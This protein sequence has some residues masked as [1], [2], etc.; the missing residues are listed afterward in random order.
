M[1]ARGEGAWRCRAFSTVFLDF[2]KREVTKRCH[3]ARQASL[4]R[5]VIAYARFAPAATSTNVVD[6]LVSLAH[7]SFFPP[8]FPLF[9]HCIDALQTAFGVRLVSP[10]VQSSSAK[11]A[12]ELPGTTS[13]SRLGAKR[14][15]R[16]SVALPSMTSAEIRASSPF[17]RRIRTAA[18]LLVR[19]VVISGS[20]R[21]RP[22]R[23][24]GTVSFNTANR[25]ALPW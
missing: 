13:T 19:E 12:V 3:D 15:V 2:E 9:G 24:D 5:E 18:S 14:L 10:S 17:S 6:S 1:A 16:I 21:R 23:C 22:S 20:Q 11:T 4:N 7:V 25:R 8:G